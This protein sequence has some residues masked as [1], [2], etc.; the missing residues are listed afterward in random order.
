MAG[1]FLTE[2]RLIQMR[3]YAIYISTTYLSFQGFDYRLTLAL[4]PYIA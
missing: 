1:A 4:N 2:T 3:K